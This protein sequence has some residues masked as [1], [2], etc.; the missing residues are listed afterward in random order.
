MSSLGGPTFQKRLKKA[1][2]LLFYERVCLFDL[3]KVQVKSK[4]VYGQTYLLKAI[5]LQ[6]TFNYCKRKYISV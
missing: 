6:Y 1:G 2:T 5:G 4:E 3:S